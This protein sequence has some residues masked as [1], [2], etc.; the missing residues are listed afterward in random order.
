MCIRDSLNPVPTTTS[1]SPSSAT[2]GDSGFTLTVNGTNF[3]AGSVVKWE[4][5]DRTTTY[6][7]ATQ[8]TASITAADITTAGTA[9]VTVFNP[10]PGG[11]E[12][13]SQTFTINNQNPVPT[14][15][16]LSPN[17]ATAG[18]SGFTLT[19]NGTNFV[20]GSKVRWNGADRTT[21]Y[22]SATRLT[23]SIPAS[24]I[25]TAGTAS[26]TVYNPA[27]GGGGGT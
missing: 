21:T 22:V 25:V 9:S 5:A 8:L 13:N 27:T 24:D 12:S 14:T 15:T 19:V 2:A 7:S 11:G 18:D 1:L 16:S 10:A 3:V 20:A 17:S 26:V 6:V 23:A 4:G